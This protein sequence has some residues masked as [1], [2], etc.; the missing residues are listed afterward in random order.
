M[1]K[2][3]NN[4]TEMAGDTELEKRINSYLTAQFIWRTH[5]PE[6]ECLEEARKVI[7]IVRECD[8]AEQDALHQIIREHRKKLVW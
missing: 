8:M 6:D 1:I 5:V 3:A 4:W 2:D 7:A